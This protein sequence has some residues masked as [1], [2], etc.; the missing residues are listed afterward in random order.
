MDFLTHANSSTTNPKTNPISKPLFLSQGTYGCIYYPGFTCRGKIQ[1]T[2]YVSKLQKNNET[3]QNELKIGEKIKQIKHNK[4]YFAPILKHCPVSISNLQAKYPEP[5][6]Q[7]KVISESQKHDSTSEF[8]V[9]KIRY[10]LGEDLDETFEQKNLSTNPQQPLL[11]LLDTYNYL[12]KSLKK[13]KKQN[14]IHYD[15]KANNIVYDKESEIPIII[16]FGLSISLDKINPTAPDPKLLTQLFFDTYEYDYWCLEPIFI[17]MYASRYSELTTP[18]TPPTTVFKIP[19]LNQTLTLTIE[20]YNQQKISD[21]LFDKY[22]QI[23]QKYMD[24]AFFFKLEF[25]SKLSQL[26]PPNQPI[27]TTIQTFNK[28]FYDKW[29]K[30]IE[31]HKSDTNSTFF[32]NLWNSRFTWDH[33]SLAVIYLDFISQMTPLPL[34]HP[35]LPI[36]ESFTQFLLNQL[37]SLPRERTNTGF[38]NTS[39]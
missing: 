32:Q 22:K 36:L 19:N 10:I 9:N 5:L 1:K 21:Y 16:D 14:I 12:S 18:Q 34:N 7:C 26:F 30:F 35:Q 8:S 38:T 2:K 39:K 28:I 23:I 17:G 29:Q 31:E 25:Q 24:Y 33:Y 20:E 11:F 13:L 3:L 6:N 4:Y 15:L 27:Q 37:L